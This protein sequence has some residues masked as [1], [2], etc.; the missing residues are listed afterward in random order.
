MGTHQPVEVSDEELLRLLK[1]A[2]AELDALAWVVGGYVRDKLLDRPHPNPDVVVERGDAL[3]L[4]DHFARLAGANPPVMFERF[5][6][7]QVTLPG[8]LVEFVNARAESYAPESRK[9]DVRPAT[10]DEDLRRRD[11]TINT[12]LMDLDGNVHDPIGGRQD[13]NARVLRT[14]TD[15]LRTFADDP[16]RMLRAVRFASELGFELAPD[17]IPA[18]RQMKGRLAPPVISAE[19]IADE[20]RRMMVSPRP[21]LA[22]EL[23]DA[24][25]LLEAILPEVAACKGVPQSGYHTH[26]VFGH[27]LLTVEGVPPDLVLRVAALFHDVG[28]PSTA[29][30]DGAFTGHENVG[31]ELARSALERLRF[32]QKEIET[33]VKLVRLHLRPVYYSSEWSDGAVRR[34]ARDAGP[35]LDRLIALARADI[36]ASAYPAPEKLDELQARLNAVLSERPSRLAP[37]VTGEDVMRARGINPGPEVGRIKKRLEEMV[38]DGE[39][40]PTREAVLQHLADHPDV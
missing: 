24:S 40:A 1:Q 38:M 9:P 7:A 13:L 21:R 4:A 18:M 5:G 17:L 8:H 33:V 19:R 31:A 23:L 29:T 34:L 3:K 10:L 27:T 26:D 2:A 12:L 15:P 20:L 25:G 16:L 30:P 32:S 36:G 35:V 28:K 22:L 37:L 11:F 14:P 39:L 6:T